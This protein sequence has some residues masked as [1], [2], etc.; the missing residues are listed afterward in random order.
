MDG[1][2]QK[3]DIPKMV[4]K[5]ANRKP[6]RILIVE[7][8]PIVM[9]ISKQL[10]MAHGHVVVS[11]VNGQQALAT[12]EDEGPFDILFSD[13]ILPDNMSGFDIQREANLL[14]PGI[15]SILTTGYI[16]L[17]SKDT[18]LLVEN[19][20]ILYKPY[21]TNDLLDRIESSSNT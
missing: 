18:R 3:I 6:C 7:D 4:R 19:S 1:D 16:D 9:A 17:T 21:S 2:L 14:Q 20:D 8:N 13:I 11:A 5:H 15:G 12:L 10:L